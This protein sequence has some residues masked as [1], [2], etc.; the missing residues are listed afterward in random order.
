[1]SKVCTTELKLSKD[2]GDLEGSDLSLL[3]CSNFISMWIAL[4]RQSAV[5]KF[6][7]FG[8]NEKGNG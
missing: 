1:M 2:H 8:W 7:G 4:Q 5:Q 3:Y 6:F